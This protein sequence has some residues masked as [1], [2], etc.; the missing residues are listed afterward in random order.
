MKTPIKRFWPIGL[1]LSAT[2]VWTV[3]CADLFPH[4]DPLAGWQR[5]SVDYI[6]KEIIKDYEAFIQTLP[7][8]ERIQLDK[9]APHP[10]E[11]GK[12]SHAIRFDVGI[13]EFFVDRIWYYVLI[14]DK[15]NKRVKVIRY[16]GEKTGFM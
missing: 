8:E 1:L 10:Y 2:L 3:G 4:S 15:E 5:Y 11:N 12:G 16:P 7:R 13:R 9:Y 6:D 14:Y